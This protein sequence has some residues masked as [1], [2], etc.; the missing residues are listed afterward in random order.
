MNLTNSTETN[1]NATSTALDRLVARTA[2][3]DAA[4]SAFDAMPL[5][6]QRRQLRGNGQRFA[7]EEQI[8]AHRAATFGA[9]RYDAM[10][11]FLETVRTEAGV[12]LTTAELA[13]MAEV[14]RLANEKAENA[15]LE[16]EF[17]ADED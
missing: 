12:G 5:V 7:T 13:E 16:R 15:R 11:E 14:E 6:V 17:A 9:P 3:I 1:S 2:P 4:R 8:D 10:M